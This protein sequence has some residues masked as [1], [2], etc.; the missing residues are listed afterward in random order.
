MKILISKCLL[1]YNCKYN[2]GNNYNEKV[3]EISKN[4]EC[5]LICPEEL[6]GLQTPRFPSEIKGDKVISKTGVDVTDNFICGAKIALKMA[7][8][9]NVK[10]AILKES[11][12]SC[13]VSSIY[14]G[15]FSNCKIKGM[16]ITA[17]MLKN[18]GIKLYSEKD[19]LDEINM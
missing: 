11:S 14:D 12:P 16:G 19:D 15:S 8:D 17:R 1:G 5:L 4:N 13:G 2:G 18:E 3:I 10:I 7:K 9:N 6:G